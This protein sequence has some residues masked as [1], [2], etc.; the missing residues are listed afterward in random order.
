LLLG[1][2]PALEGLSESLDTESIVL[3]ATA[4][5]IVV[6]GATLHLFLGRISRDRSDS[7]ETGIVPQRAKAGG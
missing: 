7:G 4:A 2:Y 6:Q 1:A 5:S 3:V